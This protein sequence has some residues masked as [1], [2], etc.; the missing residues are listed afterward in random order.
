MLSKILLYFA[1]KETHG[2]IPV[3]KDAEITEKV[4]VKVFE[5]R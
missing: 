1:M 2:H 4:T 5:R 3:P